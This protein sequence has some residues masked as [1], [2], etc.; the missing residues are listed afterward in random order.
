MVNSYDLIIERLQDI[1]E[2]AVNANN[3]RDFFLP[4]FEYIAVY[5]E[6]PELEKA[7]KA[8]VA[9]GRQ[10]IK[11]QNE[12]A[13]RALVEMRKVYKEVK[14]YIEKEKVVNKPAI[15]NLNQFTAYEEGQL[16]TSHGPIKGRYG[17]LSYVLMTLAEDEMVN[18]LLFVRKYGTVTDEHRIKNWHFSPNYEKWEQ[19]TNWLDRIKLTRVWY[20]WDRLV[21]FYSIYRDYEKMVKTKL[22]N[23][24]V[25]DAFNLN[26][27]FGEIKEIIDGKRTEGYIEFQES[28]FKTHLQR[29]H[30]FV[31][32]FLASSQIPTANVAN[33]YSLIDNVLSVNGNEIKLKKDTRKL[34][35]LELLIKKPSGIYFGEIINDVEGE[36]AEDTKKLKNTYYEVCRGISNSLAKTGITNF[37]IFDYNQAKIDKTYK[38][39][40]K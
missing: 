8:I 35:I 11:K 40:S 25:W 23:N 18:H 16:T 33:S 29:L 22:D 3:R 14:D 12:Y 34:R 19:E 4:L 13:D 6:E 38:R 37:L 26:G 27:L 39:A 7:I 31:K 9:T 21:L 32:Q 5:D 28:E 10:E 24:Q 1:Y 20:S 2:R 36:T 17:Y 15:D 30:S